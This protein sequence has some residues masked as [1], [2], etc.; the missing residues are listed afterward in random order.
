M[1]KAQLTAICDQSRLR[2]LALLS[3]EELT[4]TELYNKLKREGIVYRE[5][6]FKGL[7][8]LLK[9]GLIK[10]EFKEKIGYKYSLNF[11]EFKI[12]H[13]LKIITK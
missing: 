2:I 4:N 9:V 8:K 12:G 10:R 13:K 3:E 7:K 11:K 6:V 1:E 5:S